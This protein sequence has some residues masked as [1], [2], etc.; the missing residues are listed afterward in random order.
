MHNTHTQCR[1]FFQSEFAKF[2]TATRRD[3][4]LGSPPDEIKVPY[5]AAHTTPNAASPACRYTHSAI[6]ADESPYFDAC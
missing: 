1:Q 5:Y 3:F 4:V 6:V 2:R